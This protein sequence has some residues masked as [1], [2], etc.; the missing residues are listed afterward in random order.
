MFVQAANTALLFLEELGIEDIRP[1]EGPTVCFHANDPMEIQQKNTKTM[2]LAAS[3]MS[4]IRMGRRGTFVPKRIS[5]LEW[6]RI[7]Q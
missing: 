1:V 6:L 5:S 2:F 7:L 4:V 3:Q